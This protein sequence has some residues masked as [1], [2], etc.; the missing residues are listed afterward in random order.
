MVGV[1][2]IFAS[3]F[4]AG[5]PPITLATGQNYP[6]QIAVDDYNVYWINPYNQIPTATQTEN[7]TAAIVT[8]PKSG[9]TPT[10]LLA[11][12]GVVY[13]GAVMVEPEDVDGLVEALRKVR[14]TAGQH[15]AGEMAQVLEA[16]RREPIP[17]DALNLARRQADRHLAQ[18]YAD[19]G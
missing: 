8:V 11:G 2:T 13:A 14:T 7:R 15:F 5:G 9:G 16:W 19:N 6:D 1:Y 18:W 17:G 3:A 10:T 12:I 4:I